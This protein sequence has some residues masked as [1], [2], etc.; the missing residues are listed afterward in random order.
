MDYDPNIRFGTHTVRVTLQQWDYIG[1]VV[2]KI[3]GNCKG[4]SILDYAMDFDCDSFIESDC[5]FSISDEPDG[6]SGYWFEC[7]LKNSAGDVLQIEDSCDELDNYI[8]A[9]EIISLCEE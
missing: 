6:H 9:A 5:S 1:H 7:V 3:R 4:R 8:V 2:T